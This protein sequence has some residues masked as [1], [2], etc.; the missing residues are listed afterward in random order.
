[1]AK[2]H[3]KLEKLTE[4]VQA[5]AVYRRSKQTNEQI[6]KSVEQK[7]LSLQNPLDRKVDIIVSK[8]LNV[9]AIT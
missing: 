9:L 3:R 1:M 7:I 2:H 6:D 4:R 8:I 5:T